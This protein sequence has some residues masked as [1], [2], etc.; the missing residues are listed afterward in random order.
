VV[1]VIKSATAVPDLPAGEYKKVYSD[2]SRLY[3][4]V[5]LAKSY[6]HEIFDGGKNKE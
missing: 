4:D 2:V 3:S 1:S 6:R 5:K